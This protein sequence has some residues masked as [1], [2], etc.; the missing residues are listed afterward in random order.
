MYSSRKQQKKEKE[1]QIEEE[2]E[3]K[4]KYSLF[5]SCSGIFVYFLITK[6]FCLLEKFSTLLLLKGM[7]KK[8]FFY[9][10]YHT[11]FSVHICSLHIFR[12]DR[13]LSHFIID[14]HTNRMAERSN[15][16]LPLQEDPK[17]VLYNTHKNNFFP[18]L[19]AFENE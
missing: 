10:F 5:S 16:S 9:P 2:D 12:W 19:F 15:K 4:L 18:R 17:N 8:I 14:S 13:A 7:K 6:F 3:E 1:I 11:L